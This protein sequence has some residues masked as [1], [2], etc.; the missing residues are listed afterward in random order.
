MNNKPEEHIFRLSEIAENYLKN[1]VKVILDIGARDLTESIFLS[2]KYPNAKVISFECNPQTLTICR[3]RLTNYPN[4]TLIDKA[5]ND[6]D[7]VCKFYPINPS[8]TRTT[9]EDGNPGASSLFVANDKY[10]FETYVQDEIEIQCTR[11][12][13]SLKQLGIDKVDI[14]WMDL[15]GAELLA[16]KSMGDFLQNVS[17][18]STET[19][20]NEMYKGQAL[21]KDID[22]FLN[23]DF[24]LVY[25]NLNAIW[26]TDIVYINKKII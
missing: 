22:G 6:Y 10:P 19:E 18:I 13:T 23:N 17:I 12:D 14:I 21:F 20:M 1:E 2:E 9:W 25:G 4:I 3:E 16:L 5:V 7:G 8:K 24:K 11:V 15:Q 26:G